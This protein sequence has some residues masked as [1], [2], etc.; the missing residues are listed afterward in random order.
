MSRLRAML[1]P[2]LAQALVLLGLAAG[3]AWMANAAHPRGLSWGPT[4][5]PAAPAAATEEGGVP[6]LDL[7]QAQALRDSGAPFLDARFPADYAAGHIPGARNIPPDM[8]ADQVEAL[9]AD[10]P[11]DRPLVAYCHDPACPL[12]R[13]LA[14]NLLMLGYTGVKVFTGGLAEWAAAGLPVAVG[15]AP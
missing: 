11:K 1:L 10:V 12:G 2:A 15:D 6:A 8:F 4:P 14:E 5:V 3:L 9:L 13:D 7:A